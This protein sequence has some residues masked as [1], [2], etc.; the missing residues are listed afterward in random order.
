MCTDNMS[1]R[2]HQKSFAHASAVAWNESPL[3][4]QLH[5]MPTCHLQDVAVLFPQGLHPRPCGHP[6]EQQLCHQA[7]LPAEGRHSAA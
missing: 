2:H 6:M 1:L 7:S 5:C 3:L 4:V